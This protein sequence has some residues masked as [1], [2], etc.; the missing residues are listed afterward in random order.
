MNNRLTQGMTILNYSSLC[1]NS[2]SIILG[3]FYFFFP[4]QTTLWNF[5]GV[6]LLVNFL[7]NYAYLYLIGRYFNEDSSLRNKINILSYIYLLFSPIAVLLMNMGNMLIS[8]T[9]SNLLKNNISSYTMIFIGFFGLL[10]LCLTISLILIINRKDVNIWVKTNQQAKDGQI[11]TEKRRSLRTVFLVISLIFL[12]LGILTSLSMILGGTNSMLGFLGIGVAHFGLT[13]CIIFASMLVLL[14]KNL[15]KANWIP[16]YAALFFGLIVTSVSLLPTLAIPSTIN[17]AKNNFDDAFNPVFGG[18]WE[19]AIPLEVEEYFLKT[20]Y[21]I[22]QYFLGAKPKECKIFVNVLYF[23]GSESSFEVDKNILLYFDA[24]LPPNGGIGLPGENSILIRLHGG[25]WSFGDKGLTNMMQMNK[26]FAAQ[27]YVV[28]DIQYGL[29]ESG[30]SNPFTPEFVRGDFTIEDLVRHIGNFTYFLSSHA[31][32]YEANLDSVF[33]SGS[34]AGGQLACATALGLDSGLYSDIFNPAL[35]IRGLIPYYP[36]NRLY[37]EINVFRNPALLVGST[38]PPCLIF[39]GKQDGLVETEISEDLLN[40]YISKGNTN[41]AILYM[42]F[43]GHANDFYFSSN[44][45]QIFL[46]FMERFMY[47]FH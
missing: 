14:L 26:Y 17:Q 35:T 36:A 39:Q 9:Y 45:N 15:E 4:N 24:Y 8:V 18:S 3:F 41:C 44:Y 38:S 47:L 43:A 27:G 46:Y 22:T 19:S 5:F 21:H 29:F 20:P 2:I 30:K 28:F 42:P 32:D 1:F 23:N 11:Q 31:S 34:S 6:L 12:E 40:S 13:W 7:F 37:D 33:V 16:F 25:G 10:I